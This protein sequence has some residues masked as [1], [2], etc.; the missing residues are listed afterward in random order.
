[1]SEFV[2]SVVTAVFTIGGLIGSLFANVVMDSR[3]RKGAT[4]VSA[5]CTAGGAALMGLSN[6][7]VLLG[8]G[9]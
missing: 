1:M 8:L 3:G 9:R 6:S 4:T 2:F 5:I 7:V